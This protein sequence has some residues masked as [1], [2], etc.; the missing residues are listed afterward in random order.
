MIEHATGIDID[1]TF[2]RE[3]MAFGFEFNPRSQRLPDDPTLGTV[4]PRA[5]QVNLLGTV[6]GDMGGDNTVAHGNSFQIIII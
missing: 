3:L 4:E 5:E 2:Q 1:Q 6:G